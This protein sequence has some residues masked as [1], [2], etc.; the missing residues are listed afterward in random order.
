MKWFDAGKVYRIVH[1]VSFC[2]HRRSGHKG[3]GR[4]PLVIG[5]KYTC[6]KP[7]PYWMG[8]IFQYFF[9]WTTS[10]GVDDNIVRIMCFVAAFFF[11]VSARLF[12]LEGSFLTRNIHCSHNVAQFSHSLRVTT[13]LKKGRYPMKICNVRKTYRNHETLITFQGAFNTKFTHRYRTVMTGRQAGRHVA[14]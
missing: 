3:Q 5:C 11:I 8:F 7:N 14:L 9:Y 4:Q 1:N 2:S 6:T 13:F 12:V 10:N